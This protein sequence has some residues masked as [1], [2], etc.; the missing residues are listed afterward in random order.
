MELPNLLDE[1]WFG[2][3]SSIS[4]TLGLLCYD[5]LMFGSMKLIPK[6]WHEIND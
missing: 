2:W 3:H 6:T 5:Y 4:P 1:E